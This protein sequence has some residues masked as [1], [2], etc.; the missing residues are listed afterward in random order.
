[1]FIIAKYTSGCTLSAMPTGIYICIIIV[2]TSKNVIIIL[3]V[4][5]P[6]E[7]KLIEIET[8]K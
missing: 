2:R 5:K 1:M 3:L 4:F 6:S 7:M 8:F